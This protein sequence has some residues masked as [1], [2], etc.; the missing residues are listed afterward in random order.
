MNKYHLNTELT[1]HEGTRCQFNGGR[2]AIKMEIVHQDFYVVVEQ[3]GEPIPS[4]RNDSTSKSSCIGRPSSSK[5][6]PKCFCKRAIVAG[7]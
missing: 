3:A 4:R 6:E 5:V 1:L 2:C 7:E